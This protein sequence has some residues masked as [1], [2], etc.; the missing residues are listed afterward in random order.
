MLVYDIQQEP[1]FMY[2]KER[3]LIYVT[4]KIVVH[5]DHVVLVPSWPLAAGAMLMTL[6]IKKKLKVEGKFLFQDRRKKDTN[7]VVN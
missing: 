1:K 4:D 2:L 5:R 3:G 7:N 6:S